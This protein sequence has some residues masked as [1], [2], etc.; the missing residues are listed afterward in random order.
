MYENQRFEY[1]ALLST[2]FLK[3]ICN[4]TASNTYGGIGSEWN[5]CF[6]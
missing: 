1:T 2:I 4:H 6:P 5:Y 3:A